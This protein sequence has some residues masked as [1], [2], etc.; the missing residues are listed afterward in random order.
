MKPTACVAI[1]ALL[2]ASRMASAQTT[3][4]SDPAADAAVRAT[5]E[6]RALVATMQHNAHMAL[7]AFEDA[8]ARGRRDEVR[9]A[10]EALS[11]ADV[12]LRR[13]HD[14]LNILDAAVAM[15]DAQ[16]ALP[17][18]ARIRQRAVASHEAEM[19]AKAC[20]AT[21]VVA[22][23]DR[24]TVTLYVDPAIARFEP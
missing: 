16:M 10:D 8:R 3:G 13:S 18:L 15:R 17:A 22:V 9:C 19:T 20:S 11:R 21:E 14:D 1:A 12:A 4:S 23:G 5:T 6:G 7:E 24:T 2:A